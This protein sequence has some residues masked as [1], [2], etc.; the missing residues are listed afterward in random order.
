MPVRDS[1]AP[2]QGLA[3]PGLLEV[4][5]AVVADLRRDEP[6]QLLEPRGDVHVVGVGLV[7]LD[8]S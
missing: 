5:R 3:V 1:I 4:E 7:V 8:R 6:H 2:G